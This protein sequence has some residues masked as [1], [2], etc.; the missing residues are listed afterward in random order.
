MNN[1][2][3]LPAYRYPAVLVPSGMFIAH[4]RNSYIRHDLSVKRNDMRFI[5]GDK[6][7]GTYLIFHSE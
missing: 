2:P 1:T 6:I 5:K 7:Y 4:M 3:V